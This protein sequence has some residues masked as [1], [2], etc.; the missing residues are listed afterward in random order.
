[1]SEVR[2]KL[3]FL[4]RCLRYAS[5]DVKL[6]AY[7]AL[8]RSQLEYAT[9]LWFP[10][11]K[12]CLDNLDHVQTEAVRLTCN[13]YRI[14]DC[15]TQMARPLNL[16]PLTRRAKLTRLQLLLSL[17]RG[18]VAFNTHGCLPLSSTST[19]RGNITGVLS[20]TVTETTLSSSYFT[21]VIIEWYTLQSDIINSKTLRLITGKQVC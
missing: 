14:S 18:N 4:L 2:Y 5:P 8:V 20:G 11:T 1:M 15:P 17:L 7:T 21:R 6:A 16:S 19:E 3:F 12:K 10:H 13:K 9:S